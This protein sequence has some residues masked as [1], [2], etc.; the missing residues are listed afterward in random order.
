MN[1]FVTVLFERRFP[2]NA[3]L[4]QVRIKHRSFRIE[5]MSATN[6]PPIISV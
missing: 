6:A 3:F 2:K 4:G 5:V 1:F